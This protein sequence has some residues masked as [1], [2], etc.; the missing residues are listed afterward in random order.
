MSSF[1]LANLA[2]L[3]NTILGSTRVNTNAYPIYSA[4]PLFDFAKQVLTGLQQTLNPLLGLLPLTSCASSSGPSRL[5]SRASS[6]VP[7]VTQVCD[8]SSSSAPFLAP[9]PTPSYES[10]LGKPSK[11]KDKDKKRSHELRKKHRAAEKQQGG[12]VNA[13]RQH[14]KLLKHIQKAQPH[15]TQFN[16]TKF[17]I[18]STGYV[19]TEGGCRKKKTQQQRGSQ[20]VYRLED[21]VGEHS[22]FK[23]G[24]KPWDGKT[25]TPLLDD[26]TRVFG[27][28]GGR[29]NDPGWE[30]LQKQAAQDIEDARKRLS[31]PKDK[32]K[33]RRSASPA[34]AYGFSHRGGRTEPT[35][36]QHSPENEAIL[37]KLIHS[38]AL[39]RIASFAS[40]IFATWHPRLY[41]YYTDYLNVL[42]EATSSLCR[43]WENSVWAAMTINFGPRTACFKHLDFNNLPFGWCSITALGS[44]DSTKGGHLILWDLH[45]VVEFPPGSTIFIPSAAIYHSN[46]PVCG[47]ETRYSVTQYTAGGLFH[48]VDYGFQT[49]QNYFASLSEEETQKELERLAEQL[50]M[51]LSLFSTYDEICKRLNIPSGL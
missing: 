46:T 48:W 5:P 14:P 32:L 23:F 26:S 49:S 37:E 45:L 47:F 38:L 31:F 18:A 36:V 3:T 6:P 16:S 39:S 22:R 35:P 2:S 1:R 44:Y 21:M 24:Y 29:P 40:D 27:L 50:D 20:T 8:T 19:A 43:N 10:A 11:A 41:Q 12:S 4:N 30:A 17:P 7:N 28:L 34:A 15:R 9:V 13:K 33:H 51:G 25:P 42:L